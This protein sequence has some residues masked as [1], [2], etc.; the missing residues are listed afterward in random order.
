ML[1][2]NSEFFLQPTELEAIQNA[3][4]QIYR[5]A[6]EWKVLKAINLIQIETSA[7]QP[8][9]CRKM[10]SYIEAECYAKK[11]GSRYFFRL[12]DYDRE[13]KM[14]MLLTYF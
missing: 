11:H 3:G 12:Q 9:K 8:F 6:D 5:D 10:T 2:K 14:S 4:C 7:H 1:T 13:V